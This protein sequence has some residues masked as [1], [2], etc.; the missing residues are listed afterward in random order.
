VNQAVRASLDREDACGGGPPSVEWRIE[1]LGR[2]VDTSYVR[3]SDTLALPSCSDH[4]GSLVRRYRSHGPHGPGVYP[5]CVPGGN[6]QP[7][8]LSWDD[9]A[10]S[11][12]ARNQRV[13]VALTRHEREVLNDAGEGLTVRESAKRRGKSSETVKTQRKRIMIKLGARNI[14]QAVA[15]ALVEGHLAS[16]K[17]A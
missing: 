8:L 16:R 12:S 3:P 7:H 1:R 10:A 17:V 6:E 15:I 14:T 4:P 11:P 5:Q 13:S 9:A 2:G